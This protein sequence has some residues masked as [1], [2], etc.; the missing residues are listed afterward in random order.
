ME[1]YTVLR[2]FS[3]LK[4]PLHEYP[5]SSKPTSQRGYPSKGAPT[6]FRALPLLPEITDAF[7]IRF[8]T[9]ASPVTQWK[10]LKGREVVESPP[11]NPP[12]SYHSPPTPSIWPPEACGCAPPAGSSILGLLQFK[13]HVPPSPG[14]EQPQE[15]VGNAQLCAACIASSLAL[16]GARETRSINT[17][18]LFLFMGGV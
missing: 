7:P 6:S 11:T 12:A 4:Y 17:H 3:V 8:Q 14:S 10:T 15:G 2:Q 5:G 9:W 18:F 13:L 1:D 16:P